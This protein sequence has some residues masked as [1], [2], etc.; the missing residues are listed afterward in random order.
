L[1]AAAMACAQTGMTGRSFVVSVPYLS[2]ETV[3]SPLPKV[4]LLF[5]TTAETHIAL[6]YTVTGV[7]DGFTL[8]ANTYVERVID[9][10][11]VSLPEAEGLFNRTLRV[12]ASQ[13]IG[14]TVV[15]DRSN[16]TEAF[17]VTPDS[18]LGTEY[19]AVTGRGRDA[20]SLVTVIGVEDET[21][22]T[23]TPR[24]K[25]RSH[26]PGTSFTVTLNRGDVY[27]LLPESFADGDLSGTYVV[28]TRPCAMMSGSPCEDLIA[29]GEHFCNPLLEEIPPVSAWGTKYVAA[30]LWRQV[31]GL[32][33]VVSSCDRTELKV[34]DAKITLMR[35]E[36]YEF[37]FDGPL[38]LTASAPVLLAQLI[39]STSNGP[40]DRSTAFGDPSMVIVPPV[41]QWRSGTKVLA[42]DLLPRLADDRSFPAPWKHYA[43]I[44]LP[45]SGESALK[46]DGAA[47]TWLTHLTIGSWVIGSVEL[48]TGGHLV[49]SPD[50]F[51]LLAYGY[52]AFD[53]YGYMP[54]GF[55]RTYPLAA[56]SISHFVCLDTYDTTLTVSNS[57]SEPV[58][59]GGVSFAGHL[60]AELLAPTNLPTTIPPGGRLPITLRFKRLGGGNNIG[61]AVVTDAA[62]G[63]RLLAIPVAIY[64]DML[65]LVP[66]ADRQLDFGGV[67]PTV[68][69]VDSVIVIYN[70]GNGPLT[71]NAPTLSSP[72]L[73]VISPGFPVVLPPKGAAR[74]VI[75]FRPVDADRVTDTIRFTTG[76]CSRP[77]GVELTGIRRSGPFIDANPPLAVTKL[78]APKGRDT[79]HFVVANRGDLP[80][81]V[82]SARPVGAA[83]G[84]FLLLADP[85]GTVV[86]GESTHDIPVQYT[87]GAIGIR[88]VWLEVVTDAIN[89]DTLLI[90][91]DV[92]NDT[93]A[94][95]LDRAVI[96]FGRSVRC[97]QAPE[98]ILTI[99][100]TGTVDL[101]PLRATLGRSSDYAV[102]PEE[103][104]T[105]T[106]G[107]T[108]RLHFQ[109]GPDV[110]GAFTDTLH[111]T[112]TLC[113]ADIPVPVTGFRG[114]SS[115]TFD[116]DTLDFGTIPWCRTDSVA[117]LWLHNR[118][119]VADT[120]MLR[121]L[122]TSPAL[123]TVVPGFPITLNPGD[124]A[125]FRLTLHNV[126]GP[127]LLDSL[128]IVARGC[129]SPITLVIR[130]AFDRAR[131]DL[132]AAGIDFG[133]VTVGG[134]VRR[135]M[136]LRN[137]TAGPL[138]YDPAAFGTPVPGVRLISPTGPFIVAP[139]DSVEIVLEYHP[140]TF[141]DTVT[142]SVRLSASPPCADVITFTFAGHSTVDDRRIVLY[143]SD[144]AARAG[145]RVPLRLMIERERIES[146]RD[147]D[148]TTTLL[149]DASLLVP[150]EIRPTAD[151]LT[152]RFVGTPSRSGKEGS[153]TVEVLG[154]LPASGSVAEVS[155]VAALGSDSTTTLSVGAGSARFVDTGDTIAVAD[156]VDGVFRL[157]DFCTTGGARLIAVGG[158]S[159][160]VLLG[161]NPVHASVPVELELVET[162]RVR[163][164]V[165]SATG[166]IVGTLLDD[167]LDP[168][169]YRATLDVTS[170]PSGLYLLVLETPTTVERR[171]VLVVR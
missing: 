65:E 147:I 29:G 145:E 171:S 83:S 166:A 53:A 88:P 36:A 135:T 164:Y 154:T 21:E 38:E 141:G 163:L 8:G 40:G 148:L 125:E 15:L 80:M 86:P 20:G 137:W 136:W 46:V 64:S 39:T 126:S 32:Y 33:R 75:R 139:L 84:E 159:R 123:T 42:P 87:P 115:D 4:R 18:L 90:P 61:I 127:D 6:T 79:I 94:I 109:L 67:P 104:A 106:R 149:F 10:Q 27:Q 24:V 160:L 108:L 132:S 121:G 19:F 30:P 77:I 116:R 107:D 49:Q 1:I 150:K 113:Q 74:V 26:A 157:L 56:D 133:T 112:S 43:Q 62:C 45:A 51:A 34:N 59:V 110:R 14:L 152:A 128:R 168:G 37:P 138:S 134:T 93:L 103:F 161:P 54:G 44:A 22:V 63:T 47:P 165:T 2:P 130:A 85:A 35:G 156:T 23:I 167:R 118:G 162:G 122:P 170:M 155:A 28:A 57:S 69:Y 99:V 158:A 97:D 142:G 72:T 129:A 100:N 5:T 50:S 89:R 140:T 144:A 13:P 25:T 98:V 16:T 102:A 58:T 101:A 105:I 78:C 52:S 68:P 143:W 31:A 131:P 96:D 169:V 9:T 81:T 124:S 117:V 73:S 41:S 114:E 71:V 92:R 119:D 153:V 11:Y 151:G 95:E 91:A 48:A 120:I 66:A 70:A 60:D 111:L 82:L 17:T 7:T 146:G 55:R 76:N 12:T 3:G